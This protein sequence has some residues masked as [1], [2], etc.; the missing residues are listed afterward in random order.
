[1]HHPSAKKRKRCQLVLSRLSSSY[2][3]SISAINIFSLSLKWEGKIWAM[4]LWVWL[5]PVLYCLTASATQQVPV[6][7][8]QPGVG[9]NP[10]GLAS[11]HSA[12]FQCCDAVSVLSITAATTTEEVSSLQPCHGGTIHHLACHGGILV[13]CKNQSVSL[14]RRYLQ[15]SIFPPVLNDVILMGILLDTFSGNEN[16]HAML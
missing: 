16:M 5:A 13:Y 11:S 9:L 4:C 8:T 6:H 10:A 12:L 7:L 2:L 1:M 3:E 15:D 14:W